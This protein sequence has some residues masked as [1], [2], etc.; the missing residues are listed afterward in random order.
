MKSIA[1]KGTPLG[2]QRDTEII[3]PDQDWICY[4][5]AVTLFVWE[6]A[7][8]LRKILTSLLNLL[9]AALRPDG[10]VDI[11]SAPMW[12]THSLSEPSP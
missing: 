8:G 6:E 11:T 1:G 5:F 12:K 3:Y 2:A 10:C 9:Q 4:F 7:C